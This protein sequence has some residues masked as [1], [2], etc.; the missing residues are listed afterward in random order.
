MANKVKPC[1]SDA[2]DNW[3]SEE[4]EVLRSIYSYKPDTESEDYSNLVQVFSFTN[5][6]LS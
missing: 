1:S 6:V 2:P 5:F 4:D 3:S